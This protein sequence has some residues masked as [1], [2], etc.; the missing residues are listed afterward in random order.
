MGYLFKL[1]CFF[2]YK[3]LLFFRLQNK[4]EQ[5][6]HHS[7]QNTAECTKYNFE[8]K[9]V[10]KQ[11]IAKNMLKKIVIVLFFC[12]ISLSAQSL[13]MKLIDIKSSTLLRFGY[14]QF[15]YDCIPYGVVTLEQ[16][17]SKKNITNLCKQKI[18]RFFATNVKL[19]HIAAYRLKVMQFYMV[20][21]KKD[22]EC[23]VNLQ[24]MRSYSEFL[25][26]QGFAVVRRGFRDEVYGY[27]F[28]RAQKTARVQKRGV[29]SDPS[30]LEC[31]VDVMK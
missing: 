21:L 11:I 14:K 6:K 9:I 30:L 15:H 12:F 3:Y 5:D 2:L 8:F 29:W 1:V 20:E 28:D 10:H 7:K 4:R 26:S 31:I 27:Y 17:Y 13:P 18:K 19:Y 22:Q 24:G 23:L 16:V 25:L